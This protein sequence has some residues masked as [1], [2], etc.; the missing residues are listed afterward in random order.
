MNEPDHPSQDG[1]QLDH[2]RD[3]KPSWP[4]MIG[5]VGANQ[6][7]GE[8]EEVDGS[9]IDKDP[10]PQLLVSLGSLREIRVPRADGSL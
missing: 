5:I 6:K 2:G 9:L 1:Q 7:R 8:D 4:E 10:P 3:P